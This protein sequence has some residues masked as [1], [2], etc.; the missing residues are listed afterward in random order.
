MNG[1]IRTKEGGKRKDFL[2]NVEIKPPM[3]TFKKLEKIL[4]VSKLMYIKYHRN[5]IASKMP[6]WGCFWIV[7]F[8][9]KREI[10]L[11]FVVLPSQ[12]ARQSWMKD[13]VI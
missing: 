4:P 1:R 2:R 5:A 8:F 6:L 3:T 13:L 7:F 11:K 12:K 10:E 9:S